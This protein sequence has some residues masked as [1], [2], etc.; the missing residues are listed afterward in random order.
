[1]G[2]DQDINFSVNFFGVGPMA[3]NS[4]FFF[5]FSDPPIDLSLYTYVINPLYIIYFIYYICQ[6]IFL[7]FIFC[8]KL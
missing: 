8:L 6:M 4:F 2:N 5:F 1:M 7:I 3:Y